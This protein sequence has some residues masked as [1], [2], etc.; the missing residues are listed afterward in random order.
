MHL[1]VFDYTR[2]YSLGCVT[3]QQLWN[4]LGR[5]FQSIFHLTYNF[6]FCRTLPNRIIFCDFK[7]C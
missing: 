7:G 4:D 2:L 1:P 3:T 5:V 6:F